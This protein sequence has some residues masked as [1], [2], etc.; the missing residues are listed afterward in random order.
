M[1]YIGAAHALG[2]VG[3]QLTPAILA[4]RAPKNSRYMISQMRPVALRQQRQKKNS[5]RIT[6]WVYTVFMYSV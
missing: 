2:V 6:V 1:S 4:P 3:S 5:C